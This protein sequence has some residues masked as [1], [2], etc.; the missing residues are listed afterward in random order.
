MNQSI[1]SQIIDNIVITQAIHKIN[2]DILNLQFKSLQ[3]V[4]KQWTKEEDALL[5]QATML[6]GVHNLDRLQLIVISKTKKQIYFRIR[7]IIENP[8]MSNNQTFVKV[9]QLK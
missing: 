7:Y 9:L 5:I 1:I 8:K 6:F 3:N 4:R 2:H